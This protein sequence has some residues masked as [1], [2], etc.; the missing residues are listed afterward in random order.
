MIEIS[1]ILVS[2]AIENKALRH[3]RRKGSAPVVVWNCTSHCNLNCRH[4]Y[5]GG[6]RNSDE[7]TTQEAKRM[8]SQ[9]AD[10]GSPFMLFSGGEPL[11]RS[12]IY[13]LGKHARDS[14]IMPILSSN[15]TLINKKTAEEIAEAGFTYVGISIDG[16]SE[17][18]D[19]FR[20]RKGAF[21]EAL[22]GMRNC[23]DAGVKTGLRFTLTKF[24]YR[25]LPKVVNLLVKEG[26]H[27]MCVYHLEYGGRGREMI[28]YD[29][30]PEERRSAIAELFRLTLEAN[31]ESSLEVLTVGNYADAA[32]LYLKMLESNA[33]KAEEVYN[34]F[35]ING[36]DG[37]GEKLACIDSQG[38]VFPNQFLREEALG[39][40]REKSLKEIWESGHE[41]LR[42]LRERDKFLRG[43]CASCRFLKICRGGS[44]VRA[45]AV[46][47]DF[48]APD[49]SCYLR[50]E[51]IT[52]SS[53]EAEAMA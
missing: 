52:A 20:G 42:K 39:S 37:S 15:G 21:N 25:E 4:C 11:L 35:L 3:A 28:G 30:S 31:R 14:E 9:L 12:D 41:L 51:E 7:L 13:E 8:I 34:H 36:G 29:L 47:G 19:F 38:N 33:D 22:Q 6:A 40:V 53:I 45:L 26:F 44:R 16:L 23:R 17:T 2:G 5:A 24:N 46:Y 50:E 27:R 32:Y 18:N 49:P 43:K 48:F 1:K 10:Y